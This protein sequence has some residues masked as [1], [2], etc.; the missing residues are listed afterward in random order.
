M[1]APTD[2]FVSAIAAEVARIVL[3]ELRNAPARERPRMLDT[4]AAADYLGRTPAAVREMVRTG[5]LIPVRLDGRVFFD[6]E[7]LDRAIEEAK[8]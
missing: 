3:A 4:N 7:D 5:K 6:R 8:R 1:S 2:A